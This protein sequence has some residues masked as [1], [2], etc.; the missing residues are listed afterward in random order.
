MLGLFDQS[1]GFQSFPDF[2]VLFKSQMRTQ[3]PGQI[4]SQ[5]VLEMTNRVTDGI[6]CEIGFSVIG[7]QNTQEDGRVFHVRRDIHLRHRYQTGNAGVT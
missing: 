1:Q 4:I 3:S 7:R 5:L 2:L 6:K